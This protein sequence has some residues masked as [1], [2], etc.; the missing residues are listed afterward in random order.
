[1]HQHIVNLTQHIVDD[2]QRDMKLANSKWGT[3]ASTIRTTALA[4]CYLVA[5]YATPVWSRSKHAHLL[6]PELLF[7]KRRF[8][9]QQNYIQDSREKRH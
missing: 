2:Y 5:K 7:L 1:M 8:I 3:N 6:Y 9:D 4:L